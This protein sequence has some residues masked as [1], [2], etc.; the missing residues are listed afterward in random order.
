MYP[1]RAPGQMRFPTYVMESGAVDL[2][3]SKEGLSLELLACNTPFESLEEMCMDLKMPISAIPS[4]A[5]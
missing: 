5:G 4:F 1:A 2:R 3:K